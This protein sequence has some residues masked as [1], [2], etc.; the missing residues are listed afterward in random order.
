MVFPSEIAEERSDLR[1]S[2][3]GP[4]IEKTTTRGI[5]NPNSTRVVV[6]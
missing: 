6:R 4:Y 5:R 1:D 2:S 3:R